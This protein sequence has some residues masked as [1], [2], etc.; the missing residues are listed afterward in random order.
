MD[1]GKFGDTAAASHLN[2]EKRQW[3]PLKTD[4]ILMNYNQEI[5]VQ[6][7]L[8]DQMGCGAA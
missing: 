5:R 8:E 1:V 2:L 7:R 6:Q 4:F 3:S